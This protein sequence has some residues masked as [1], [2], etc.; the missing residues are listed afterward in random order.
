MGK[1]VDEIIDEGV[2]RGFGHV[3]RMEN[4]RIGKRLY[5]GEFADSTSVGQPWKEVV[6]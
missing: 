6:D 1:W 5:V 4:H 3:E 2:L